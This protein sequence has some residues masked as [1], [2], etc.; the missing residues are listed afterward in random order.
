MQA[1]A[2]RMDR[3][4]QRLC[5]WAAGRPVGG[6]GGG[7]GGNRWHPLCYAFWR[8]KLVQAATPVHTHRPRSPAGTGPAPRNCQLRFPIT[9]SLQITFTPLLKH[10]L[11]GPELVSTRT[12]P[13]KTKTT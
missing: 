3:Q 13:L 4:W 1:G 8:L 5:W 2:R 7:G 6:S 9:L 12:R 11:A 10:G